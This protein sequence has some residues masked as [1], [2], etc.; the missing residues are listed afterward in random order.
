[1][2]WKSIRLELGHTAEFPGGSVSRA[3]LIRLPL[4]D[5]DGVDK[6]ALAA[7]PMKA[8][9]L[10]QWSSDPEESGLLEQTD[11]SWLM[12]SH[13]RERQFKLDG[14]IRLGQTISVVDPDG[15][16]LPFRIASVR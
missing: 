2:N 7:F 8:T 10:R 3:Y 6:A 1:M 14:M 15:T 11:A 5:F 13:G 4:D 12:R 16:S 9:V